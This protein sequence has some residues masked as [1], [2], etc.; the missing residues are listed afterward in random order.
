MYEISK[1]TYQGFFYFLVTSIILICNIKQR[2]VDKKVES[3]VDKKNFHGEQTQTPSLGAD[4]KDRTFYNKI[5]TNLNKNL[6]DPV[7]PELIEHEN[8]YED[9]KN[10]YVYT[11]LSLHVYIICKFINKCWR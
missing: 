1:N 7:S 6:D 10:R 3:D 9:T 2:E 4:T 8:M 5:L 11:Y